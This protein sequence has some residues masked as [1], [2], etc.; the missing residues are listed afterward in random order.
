MRKAPRDAKSASFD[1]GGDR[2]DVLF[3]LLSHPFRRFVLRYLDAAD[4][5]KTVGETA[6]E[7]GAWQAGLPPGDR[8]ARGTDAIESALHHQHLPKMAAANVIEHELSTGTLTLGTGAAEV[9]PY[10]D[11]IGDR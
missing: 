6:T 7:L 1:V 8:S 2:Q 11:E 10:L 3:E 5:A 9:I 4:G